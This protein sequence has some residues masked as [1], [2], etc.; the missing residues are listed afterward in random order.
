MNTINTD[1]YVYVWYHYTSIQYG[2]KAL[3]TTMATNNTKMERKGLPWDATPALATITAN[4]KTTCLHWRFT[5]SIAYPLLQ[6]SNHTVY[7]ACLQMPQH[8]VTHTILAVWHLIWRSNVTKSVHSSITAKTF[9][10]WM[11]SKNTGNF[12]SERG[13]DIQTHTHTHTHTN[14]CL[15]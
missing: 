12:T 4:S 14:K 9:N 15:E 3:P 5:D 8:T 10:D 11:Q 2:C 7:N 13:L 6:I 1:H